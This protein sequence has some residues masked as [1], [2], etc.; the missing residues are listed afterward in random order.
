MSESIAL[1]ASALPEVPA[2]PRF[3]WWTATI[4][5]LLL[6]QWFWAIS[7]AHPPLTSRRPAVLY[8]VML[9]FQW[10]MFYFAYRGIRA[11]GLNYKDLFQ[12]DPDFFRFLWGNAKDTFAFMLM[13]IGVN[14]LL[15]RIHQ[16]SGSHDFQSK[17]PWQY[18]LTLLIALSA[19]YTEEVI[20]RGFLMNQFTILLRSLTAAVYLQAIVF[21]LA[22]GP[23]QNPTLML[24]RLFMGLFFAFFAVRRRSLW[25]GISAHSFLDVLAMT[26]QHFKVR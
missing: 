14:I 22:H 16:L 11:S 23:R 21:A 3:T 19:G 9:I 7:A 2:R 13:I 5:F 25:P 18:A 4:L 26:V 10:G 12:R 24:S 20:F 8:L 17:T 6:F 1:D 15:I